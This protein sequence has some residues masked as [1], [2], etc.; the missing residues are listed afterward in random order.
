MARIAC[1]LWLLSTPFLLAQ[2]PASP[3]K[4]PSKEEISDWVKQLGSAKFAQRESAQHVLIKIGEAAKSQVEA[5]TQS[6][7]AEVAARA[8]RILEVWREQLKAQAA[9]HVFGLYESRDA[10]ALVEVRRTDKP[11]ILVLC[12]YEPVT[13]EV[14]VAEGAR[15][16]E[17]FASGYHQQQVEGVS[18]PVQTF[19]YDQRSRDAKGNTFYFY[20]YDHD[21]KKYP[22]MVNKVR[23]LTGKRV[24]SFQGRYAFKETPFYVDKPVVD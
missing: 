2:A 21:E 9:V 11:V 13:W 23:K 6:K 16:L 18:C 15:L 3:E 19:S 7:D 4:N 10:N 12:A 5:A 17:V 8:A 20:T 14:T 1:F 24:G 22:D